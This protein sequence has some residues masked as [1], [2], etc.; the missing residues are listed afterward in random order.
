[1]NIPDGYK[2]VYQGGH[3]NVYCNGNT[4]IKTSGGY[5]GVCKKITPYLDSQTKEIY[6]F[7][8]DCGNWRQLEQQTN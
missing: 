8:C 2:L 3:H 5:A 6:K 4:H 7:K 1:M